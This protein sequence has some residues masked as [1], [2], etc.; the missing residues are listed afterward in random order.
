MW[1]NH[2]LMGEVRKQALA[3]SSVPLGIC[4]FAKGGPVHTITLGDIRDTES[5][6]PR[7]QTSS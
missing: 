5:Q 7:L 1:K 3:A 2:S 4:F 6:F